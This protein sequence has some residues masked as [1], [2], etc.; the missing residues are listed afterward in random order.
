M[1][2][3]L[4]T[5]LSVGSICFT[6][7]CASIVTGSEDRVKISSLPPGARYETNTGLKGTTPAEIVVADETTLQVRCSMAGYQDASAT[8]EPEMSLWFLGNVL[9]AGINP[10]VGLG[11][12]VIDLGFD[13]WLTHDDELV[14]ELMKL[15][16]PVAAAPAQP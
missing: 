16:A 3:R 14:I 2:T 5:V 9:L 6:A 13:N 11:G 4:G 15:S 8:L 12:V 1:P 10:F 7:S